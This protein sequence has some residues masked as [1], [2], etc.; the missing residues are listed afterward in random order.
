MPSRL[1]DSVSPYLRA[2]ADQP[3]DWWPWGAEAFAEAARRDLPV[4]VSIGYATCHW[5]HVMARESFADPALAEYLNARFVAVKVDREEHPDVDASYLAAAGAFT[6]HLGWPLNAFATPDGRPF[7]AGTYSPPQP[8]GSHPSFRQVLEAVHDA[9][10]ERRDEV[11]ANAAGIAGALAASAAPEPSPLPTREQLTVAVRDLAAQED[12]EFGGFGTAPKFPSVPALQFLLE[13]GSTGDAEALALA[14]RGLL[15]MADSPLRD[16]VEGGF[17]RY[18]TQRDWGEPHYER[19]LTDNALLLQAF[20]AVGQLNGAAVMPLALGVAEFLIRSLQ[21]PDGGFGSAQDSESPV[22]GVRSEGGYYALDAA[23]RATQPQPAV[24]GKVLAGWNGLAIAALAQAGSLWQRPGWLVAARQAADH[25]LEL[26]VLP[27]GRLVRASLDGEPSD[28]VATLEDHGLLATGLLRLA[29]AVG[30]P[31]YARA[32]LRLLDACL[33][34]GGLPVAPG[35]ADPVLAAAGVAL[36]ADPSEGAYPSGLSA[37]ADAALLA[38]QLT[39][40]AEYRAAAEAVV[41][42]FGQAALQRPLASGAMLAVAARLAEPS[43]QLVVTEADAATAPAAMAGLGRA[44]HRAGVV[45]VVQPEGRMRALAEAG[46]ALL[47]HRPAQDG[48]ATAYLCRD[49]VCALPTTD[50]EALA[51]AL[52]ALR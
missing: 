12:R 1:S 37:I 11:R 8:V 27:D 17:F 2:H 50:P 36:P 34:P 30:E 29:T 19:M 49:L 18:A 23:A 52:G 43:L 25:L 21:R 9:W 48:R 41:A 14:E 4:L 3:V 13:R 24:D 28:A 31:R 46:L 47:E 44:W 15:A 26:H 45:V 42:C 33:V 40:R 10:T 16:P 35:G 22:D 20:A 39:G 6:D 5:C 51:D 32:A 7:Y 38:H